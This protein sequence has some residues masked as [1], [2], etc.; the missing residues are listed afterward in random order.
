[1]GIVEFFKK[2]RKD[3]LVHFSLQTRNGK[4]ETLSEITTFYLIVKYV[5]YAFW[6][7]KIKCHFFKKF[8]GQNKKR[9]CEFCRGKQKND[10]QKSKKETSLRYTPFLINQNKSSLKIEL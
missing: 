1:M 2:L 8:F 5:F 10:Y 9:L 3:Y 7:K 4:M 6:Q